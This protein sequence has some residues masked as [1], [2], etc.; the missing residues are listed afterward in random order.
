MTDHQLFPHSRA[1]LEDNLPDPRA[2]IEQIIAEELQEI[3][4]NEEGNPGHPFRKND[5]EFRRYIHGFNG[6]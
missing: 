6:S 5:A 3:A 2:S 1:D 4:S